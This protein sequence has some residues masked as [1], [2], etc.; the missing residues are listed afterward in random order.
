MT[1]AASA[2]VPHVGG[3]VPTAKSEAEKADELYAASRKNIGAITEEEE[4][5]EEEEEAAT[6]AEGVKGGSEQA[7]GGA[8]PVDGAGG[9]GGGG[10]GAVGGGGT[11]SGGAST[12]AAS[13]PPRRPTMEERLEAQFADATEAQDEAMASK[14]RAAVEKVK[15]EDDRR[16]TIGY[17]EASRA[18]LDDVS[19]EALSGIVREDWSGS[20]LLKRRVAALRPKLKT[21]ELREQRDRILGLARTPMDRSVL[22]ERVLMSVYKA[23][24]KEEQLPPRFGPRWETIGFQ[25]DDPATDLR[26]AGMLALLQ[27]IHMARYRP[28]L[29]QSMFALSKGGADYPMMVVSIN[30]T[31][32]AMQ[33]L[34]A[35]V[36]TREANKEKKLYETFHRFH[37][38]LCLYFTR[39]WKRRGLS[40]N[41]FGF[42]KKELEGVAQKKPGQLLAALRLHDAGP[43]AAT[44]GKS[45]DFA[46]FG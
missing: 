22:H 16:A 11:C 26:G 40:V 32:V 14:Q 4:E 18:L 36:L 6:V 45:K 43:A 35:G 37:A 3:P 44:S 46:T 7:A 2:D 39:E 24:T 28:S 15:P 31:H 9:G 27:M 19:A 1:R 23:I 13:A 5:E 17:Y 25:G 12:S 33:A 20:S 10:G 30:F 41:D 21:A 8:A 29:A 42:L 38:A 34:R